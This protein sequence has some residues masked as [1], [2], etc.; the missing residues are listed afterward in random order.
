[1]RRSRQLAEFAFDHDGD[2]RWNAQIAQAMRGL[3][4][5]GFLEGARAILGK[6]NGKRVAILQRGN[7]EAGIILEY[8]KSKGVKS[9]RNTLLLT[10]RYSGRPGLIHLAICVFRPSPSTTAVPHT[11]VLRPSRPGVKRMAYFRRKSE[12][13]YPP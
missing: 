6:Q 13:F 10:P 4:Y 3:S 1:M 5:S 7:V 9:L 2:F 8:Q 12:R 11:K